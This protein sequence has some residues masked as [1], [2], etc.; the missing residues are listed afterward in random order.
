MTTG[1]YNRRHPSPESPQP[2]PHFR[3][4]TT[5]LFPE[6]PGE[7]AAL[8][9]EG[10][11]AYIRAFNRAPPV[12]SATIRLWSQSRPKYGAPATEALLIRGLVKLRLLLPEVVVV[13]ITLDN[14]ANEQLIVESVTCFGPREQVSGFSQTMRV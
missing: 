1:K 8:T 9:A 10:L 14:I 2:F 11:I 3:P 12:P 13:Y 5:S 6:I 4:T 7:R